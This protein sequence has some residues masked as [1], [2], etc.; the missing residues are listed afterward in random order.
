MRFFVSDPHFSHG[1]IIRFERDQ[2]SSIE[3]HDGFLVG[4]FEKWASK[5]KPGD[6][7]FVLGDWGSLDYLWVMDGFPCK[8]VFVYG[9]HDRNEDEARFA[10]HF[11]EVHLYPYFLSNKL[12]VS[13]YPVAV[14]RDTCNVH[15]HTHRSKLVDDNHV[16]A[17]MD[18]IGYTPVTDKY[19]TSVYQ[20]LPKY[21]R[22]FLYE[23]F[24]QDY[25][26]TKDVGLEDKVMDK[27]GVIDLPASR[28]LR[29]LKG[30]PSD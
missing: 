29:K 7:F 12:V 26:F 30:L 1:N 5:C 19:L 22:R 28:A 18:V 17:S 4:M 23:P 20:R 2:F 15:G 24:A 27:D 6:E 14:Y 8:K 25:V 9:N 3:E 16:C 21:D 10:E 11:D 13:H